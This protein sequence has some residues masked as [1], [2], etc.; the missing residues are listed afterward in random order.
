MARYVGNARPKNALNTFKRLGHYLGK[1]KLAVTAV[2]L[3]VF[4]STGANI[5]GTYLLKPV[6]NLYI[7]PRDVA[8]LARAIFLMALM[9]LVG[10]LATFG[11]NQLMAITAQKMV[12]ELRNDLFTH[13]QTLPL[14][15]FDSHTHGELMSRFTNDVDTVTQALNNCFTMLVQ[16]FLMIVGTIA[17][18]LILNFWLSLIVLFCLAMMFLFIQY[19][20]KKSKLHYDEQ[21]KYLGDIN[22]FI[23]EMVEGQKVEKVFNHE[24]KDFE[25]FEKRNERLR[26]SSTK[27]LTYSGVMIPTV[28]SIS[29]FNYAHLAS[30]LFQFELTGVELVV[31]ALLFQQLIMAASFDDL[32]LFQHQDGLGV[33]HGGEAVGDDEDGPPIH[34]GIHPLFDQVLGAGVDGAGGFIQNE[35]RRLGDGGPGDGQQ[36]PLPLGEVGA[37]AGEL[38][39]IPLWQIGRAHV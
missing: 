15:Y 9:Y 12:A 10:V 19:S 5:L 1:H 39:G 28:V 24:A 35:H 27:A 30:S 26:V 31:P 21:Q 17:T 16:S 23:E 13:I 4:V 36:L 14:S 37:I 34:Q 22:G 7:L 25:E 3:M 11:Y 32:P 8:G 29:Y 20:G 6:I 2:I 18:I 33:T 38:G